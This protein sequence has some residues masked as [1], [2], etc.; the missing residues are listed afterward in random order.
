MVDSGIHIAGAPAEHSYGDV[1]SEGSRVKVRSAASDRRVM[2]LVTKQSRA[3]SRSTSVRRSTAKR[4]VVIES[5]EG[6]RFAYADTP[7][8]NSQPARGEQKPARTAGAD[9]A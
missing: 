5:A 2:R 3:L 1:I 6:I 9:P 4:G 7:V 8:P